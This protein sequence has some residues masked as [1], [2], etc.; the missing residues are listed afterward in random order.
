MGRQLYSFHIAPAFECNK[1]AYL[2]IKLIITRTPS[3]AHVIKFSIAT[4]DGRFANHGHARIYIGR[5]FRM[6][7]SAKFAQKRFE[8]FTF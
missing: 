3:K 5:F 8:V 6:N 2:A 1:L 4:V 7:K